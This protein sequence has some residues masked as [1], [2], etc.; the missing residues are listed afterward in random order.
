VRRKEMKVGERKIG[1]CIMYIYDVEKDL[2]RKEEHV[3]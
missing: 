3:K 2:G 1:I